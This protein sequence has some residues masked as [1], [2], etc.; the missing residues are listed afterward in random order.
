MFK[1]QLL[2]YPGPASRTIRILWLAAGADFAY[3]YE[4]GARSAMPE[5]A[6][7]KTLRADL[8]QG[9]AQLVDNDPFASAPPLHALPAKHLAIRDRAWTI[10]A[11]LPLDEPAL[12]QARTRGALITAHSA[13][14][15]VSYPTIYRYLRR[16]W[17]RGQQINALLPDYCNSGAPG[18]TRGSSANVK[19]G[20][21]R[22]SGSSAGLNADPAIRMTFGAAVLRYAERHAAFCRRA[23]YREMIEAFFSTHSAD[24]LPSFGQFNYWI[25]KDACLAKLAATQ[26]K[27]PQAARVSLSRTPASRSDDQQSSPMA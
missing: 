6:F 26:Q 2:H 1:N 15:G 18:K 11:G 8:A 17:E 22:K 24:A 19:R 5:K 7:L 14:H 20:R 21:P 27:W 12:F 4:L 23:A 13:A 25:E 9:H 16:Y 3:V 10:I